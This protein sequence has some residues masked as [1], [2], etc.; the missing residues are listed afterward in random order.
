MVIARHADDRDAREQEWHD[1]VG[2]TDLAV[3]HPIKR[4]PNI[5]IQ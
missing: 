3:W 5:R 2:A 4:T 1:V